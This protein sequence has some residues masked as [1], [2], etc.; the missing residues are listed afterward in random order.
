MLLVVTAAAAGAWVAMAVAAV[1]TLLCSVCWRAG[2]GWGARV[3]VATRRVHGWLWVWAC[4]C[5][6]VVGWVGGWWGV[7]GHVEACRVARSRDCVARALTAVGLKLVSL[8]IG[9]WGQRV[10]PLGKHVAFFLTVVALL[11]AQ[12]LSLGAAAAG[13]CGVG[14]GGVGRIPLM[15]GVCVAG[16]GGWVGGEEGGGGGRACVAGRR[17]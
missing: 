2:A 6:G 10:G 8:Q 9:A 13:A 16:G 7:G 12:L 3:R 5:V 4:V 15:C 17:A 11:R 14:N 1:T